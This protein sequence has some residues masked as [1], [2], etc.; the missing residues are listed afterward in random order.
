MF[1]AG[2]NSRHDKL[3]VKIKRQ[4]VHARQTYGSLSLFMAKGTHWL[5]NVLT[6]SNI[7]KISLKLVQWQRQIFF[8]SQ[9]FKGN[10]QIQGKS[11]RADDSSVL[12]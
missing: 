12:G 1:T 8:S 6:F 2:S 7:Y 11:L 10:S 4:L 3:A 5:K 9:N